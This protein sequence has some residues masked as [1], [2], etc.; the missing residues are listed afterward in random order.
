MAADIPERQ[1]NGVEPLCGGSDRAGRSTAVLTLL[2]GC[3]ESPAT[4]VARGASPGARIG[5]FRSRA[6]IVAERVENKE[7]KSLVMT[8]HAFTAAGQEH[9]FVIAALGV[10]EDADTK[11]RL[12]VLGTALALH[13]QLAELAASARRAGRIG[14]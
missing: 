1:P 7:G 9:R 4:L 3:S 8:A 12:R 14:G 2:R 6:G 10:G 13:D 5:T 11:R